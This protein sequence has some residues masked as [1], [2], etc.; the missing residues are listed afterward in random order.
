MIRRP[1]WPAGSGDLFRHAPFAKSDRDHGS[2]AEAAGFGVAVHAAKD[3]ITMIIMGFPGWLACS[4]G[5]LGLSG[6]PA[7][8]ATV[9]LAA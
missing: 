4:G 8:P 9:A 6:R 2:Q 7:G 3:R 5:G 1:A